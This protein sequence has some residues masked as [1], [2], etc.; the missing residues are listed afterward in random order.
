MAIKK[1][2]PASFS[3][4]WRGLMVQKMTIKISHGSATI[5]FDLIGRTHT[6]DAAGNSTRVRVVTRDSQ[7]TD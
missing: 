2:V 6:R 7:D 3:N 1:A 4:L 5:D